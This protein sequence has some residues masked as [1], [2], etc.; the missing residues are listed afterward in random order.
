MTDETTKETPAGSPAVDPSPGTPAAS[1]KQLL[2]ARVAALEDVV[3]TL[4]EHSRAAQHGVVV[5]WLE[6]LWGKVG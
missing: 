1:P 3:K 4:A 2:E 6:R 5:A